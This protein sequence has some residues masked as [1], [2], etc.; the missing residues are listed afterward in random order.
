MNQTQ[1]TSLIARRDEIWTNWE[2]AG[3]DERINYNTSL[4]YSLGACEWLKQNPHLWQDYIEPNEYI[5]DDIKIIF[6]CLVVF[7]G[8]VLIQMVWIYRPGAYYN[9]EVKRS[10]EV[11][12]AHDVEPFTAGKPKLLDG[13]DLTKKPAAVSKSS[14]RVNFIVKEISCRSMKSASSFR[15]KATLA[16]IMF[17]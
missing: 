15:S 9:V 10:L 3:E 16:L 7:I 2:G 14:T 13:V 6:I 11:L 12:E 4:L 1:N 5:F 8:Y 17:T